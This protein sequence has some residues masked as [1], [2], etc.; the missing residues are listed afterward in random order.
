MSQLDAG[1]DARR[2]RL[3]ESILDNLPLWTLV[4]A[5]ITFLY[6]VW[7]TLEILS[8]YSGAIPRV[9]P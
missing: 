2:T 3:L 9:T 4:A 6:L 7:V 1:D 8:R 5:A